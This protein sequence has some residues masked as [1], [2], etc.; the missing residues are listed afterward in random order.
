M[1]LQTKAQRCNDLIT[2]AALPATITP[3]YE[4]HFLT[5]KKVLSIYDDFILEIGDLEYYDTPM[6]EI[7]HG[8]LIV[9]KRRLRW[10]QRLLQLG[11]GMAIDERV[12]DAVMMDEYCNG[13]P[14]GIIPSDVRR[15]SELFELGPVRE[16]E[17]CDV[18]S[19]RNS[20][21]RV[22]DAMKHIQGDF[23]TFPRFYHTVP[24]RNHEGN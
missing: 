17:Y 24:R 18:I 20:E 10:G 1:D 11:P 14:I 19:Y 2:L 22:Y 16:S 13:S 7:R 21:L 4:A 15:L 5:N 12:I 9:P 3:E 6:G 23:E 8:D